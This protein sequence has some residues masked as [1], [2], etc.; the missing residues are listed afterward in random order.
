TI[1]KNIYFLGK[2]LD[3]GLT[4]ARLKLLSKKKLVAKN[5]KETFLLNI[6]GALTAIQKNPQDFELLPNEFDNLAKALSKNYEP[7]KFESK[8]KKSDGTLFTSTKAQ[9]KKEDL[10]AIISEYNKQNKTKLYELTQL[11]SNFYIDFVNSNLFTMHNDVVAYMGLYAF[12]IRDFSV[13]KYVSFFEYFYKNFGQYQMALAQ[14]NYAYQSGFPNTDLL[15]RLII[16]I[17]DQAYEEVN[18]FSREYSFEKKLNKSDNIEA[19]IR[20]GKEIFSKED[21]REIGRAH[22]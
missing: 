21:I 15:N 20:N 9:G 22:V 7:I 12:L 5:K 6:K 1:E 3:L 19:T 11:I 14:A 8:E 17:L 4:D 16:D 13:F 10:E 18:D 2:I